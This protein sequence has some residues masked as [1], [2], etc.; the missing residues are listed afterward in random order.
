MPRVFYYLHLIF[1]LQK[2]LFLKNE[3]IFFNNFESMRFPN[4]FLYDGNRSRFR[5]FQ[6]HRN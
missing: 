3:V 5:I 1:Y 4:F 2:N 6:G